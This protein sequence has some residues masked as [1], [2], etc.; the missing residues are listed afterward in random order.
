[1]S[2][3][4]FDIGTDTSVIAVARRRVIDVLQNMSGHRKTPSMVGFQGKQRCIGDDA[5]AQ[6]TNNFK[7]T[8]RNLKRLLGMQFDDPEL[9]AELPYLPHKIT[10]LPNGRVGITVN[11]NDEPTTFSVEQLVGALFQKLKQVTE[12]RLEAKLTDCVVSCPIYWTDAQ[13]RALMDA[14]NIAGLNGAC[15]AIMTRSCSFA[16]GSGPHVLLMRNVCFMCEIVLFSVSRDERPHCCC[17]QL[18]YS[19]TT[20]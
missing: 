14:C 8:V 17:A 12:F 19:S 2:V 4:G 10:K 11:Y 6:Y 13:R 7:N 15:S 5:L 1:M 20:A 3:A 18:R 9:K 16:A